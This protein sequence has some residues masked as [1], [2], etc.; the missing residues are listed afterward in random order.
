MT[1]EQPD[2]AALRAATIARL[3]R[4]DARSVVPKVVRWLPVFHAPAFERC[5]CEGLR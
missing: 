5:G 1:R 3:C 2:L 4:I